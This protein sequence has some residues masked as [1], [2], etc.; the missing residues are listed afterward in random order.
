MN[1]KKLVVSGIGL[2]TDISLAIYTYFLCS[3]YEKFQKYAKIAIG[4][5][6]LQLEVYK[7]L[8]QVLTFVLFAFVLLH[9]IIY[10][11]YIRGSKYASKYINFYLIM[12]LVSL[13]VSNL[14]SFNIY[15]LIGTVLYGICFSK[16]KT[17]G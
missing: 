6:S 10:F 12:A 15:F 13:V 2:G 17:A 14:F 5:P 3:N 9:L 1:E 7:M 16:F 8:L 4:D 11:L